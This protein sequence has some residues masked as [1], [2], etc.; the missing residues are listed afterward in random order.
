M[1]AGTMYAREG[2]FLRV[3]RKRE[4]HSAAKD[5]HIPVEKGDQGTRGRTSQAAK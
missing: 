3:D 5:L 2:E 4:C 1:A